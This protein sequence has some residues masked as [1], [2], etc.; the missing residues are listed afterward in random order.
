[1]RGKVLRRD[2]CN[3]CCRITPAHAGKRPKNYKNIDGAKD[4]PRTCGEKINILRDYPKCKGSP[5]HMQGKASVATNAPPIERITPAHAGKRWHINYIRSRLGDHPRT[6]GEKFYRIASRILIGESPPHMRGKVLSV[7]G[8][9]LPVR[10]TPAHA[11]KRKSNK[12]RSH[13]AKDH[14]RTCG[15]KER[16]GSEKSCVL[17]S[18]PHMRGKVI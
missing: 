13:Y 8:Y 10:I 3:C 2:I 4:H 11:G 14:P 18:P 16:A 12:E 1:M 5:P 7:L 15:E 17:G 6:C 9:P